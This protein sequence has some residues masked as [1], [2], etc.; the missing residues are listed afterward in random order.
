MG[1]TAVS[2]PHCARSVDV[3]SRVGRQCGSLDQVIPL[4]DEELRR[5]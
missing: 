5:K 1:R 2:L 4:V 3:S